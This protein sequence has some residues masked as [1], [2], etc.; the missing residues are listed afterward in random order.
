MEKVRIFDT[1]LR[2]GE[3]APGASLD[4]RQKIQVA[5]QLER[6]NVDIIEA[7]FPISSEID[8][9][10]VKT[11]A[12]EIKKP[13]VCALARAKKEDIDAAYKSIK[14]AKNKRIHVFLATSKIHM[15]YKLR[16]AQDEILKQAVE[17]VKYAKGKIEDIEF[18]PE[19]ASRTELDFLAQIV[20]AV[21][22][23][24][25]STVNI[26]DTVGYATPENFGK[27]IKYLKDNVANIDKAVI[28]AHCHDDLGMATANSL[29]AVVN[30]ARQV[31]CTINGI[32]ERA[33]S[34]PLEEIV[35]SIKTRG[36]F[37][38]V[39]TSIKTK[40]LYK[41]SRLISH[42]MGIKMQ[43]NKAIIGENA[44]RH[45]SG[46]HQDGLIKERSTYEIMK[47][48]DIGFKESKLVLGR[49]S[50]R[51]AFK[52]RLQQLG[53]DL[54][55]AELDKAFEKFMHLAN[56]KKEVYDEDLQTIVEGQIADIPQI[57]KLKGIKVTSETDKAPIA[58]V[59]MMSQGKSFQ[60]KATGDGPVDASYK[61]IDKIVKLKGRLIDYSLQS[62]SI[63]KDALG[64]VVIKVKFKN[65]EIIAK[66]SSTDIFEASAAAYI[67]A[68][69]KVISSK[70][71]KK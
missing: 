61:A 71:K 40:E 36:D 58:I 67:N 43:P 11:I 5:H 34:A 12:S 41:S 45:E 26:P 64:E 57:W 63:G 59:K 33:G 42:L 27:V 29:A 13:V 23:A 14:P 49:H 56:K 20:E 9:K 38:N 3:Q 69:N 17:S 47:P 31:E 24:G 37:Y 15:Q 65:Q 35:M 19:D 44:F 10:A 32:G 39:K 18:S 48:E 22:D 7:G 6:L 50:G 62:V 70:K 8:F 52:V 21:I 55:K 46:I 28:S 60:S 2:D 16:K 1:T 51:H 66:A 30:G 25:A 54:D 68:I 4:L 53:F